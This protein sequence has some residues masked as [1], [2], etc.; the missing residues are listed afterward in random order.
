MSNIKNVAELVEPTHDEVNRQRFVSVFRKK[1]LMDFAQDMRTVYEQRVEPGFE[2]KNGR[3]PKDAREIRKLM[4]GEPIFE[5]WSTLRHVAQQMTWWSVQP[6]IE[7]KLPEMIGAAADARQANPAGGSLELDPDLEIPREVSDLD[8]HLMPGCFHS[9]YAKDDVA[10]GAVYHYGTQVF[11]GGFGQKVKPKGDVATSIA[12]YLKLRH[13]DFAPQRILDMGCTAGANTLPY[14]EVYPDAE[15]HGID[16][17]AP[18]LRFGHAWAEASRQKVHYHQRNAEE[19][20][21]PDNHFDIVTSSF[22]FHELSVKS[23][24]KVLA[25]CHRILKPGG[26]M[27]HMELPPSEVTDTYYNFYLDWDAFYNNEPHYEAFRALDFKK[28][29]IEAGFQEDKLEMIRIPNFGPTPRE[30]FEAVARGG[31][32]SRREHGL[33]RVWFTFGGWK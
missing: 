23:T 27:L 17:G 6:G 14:L 33:G 19:S 21:F 26:L 28:T 25:E 10:Q 13:P 24:K 9:E 12:H 7:R 4:L 3:K 1:I 31:E 15:L 8:V 11:Y 18:V 32:T 29:I 2:K 5:G 20:G 30:E 16:V 22:F